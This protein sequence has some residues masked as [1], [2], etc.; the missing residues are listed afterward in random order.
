MGNRSRPLVALLLAVASLLLILA[1]RRAEAAGA[2]YLATEAAREE[3][4]EL[5]LERTDVAI[6]IAGSVASATVTQRFKNPLPMPIEVVYAFPLPQR[7]AV[8]AMEMKIGSRTVTASIARRDE[9]RAVY[10]SA[11][12]E[13]R[14]A[15]LLEQEHG[16]PPSRWLRGMFGNI[17]NVERPC[18]RRRALPAHGRP[19][20]TTPRPGWLTRLRTCCVEPAVTRVGTL[21]PIERELDRWTP[22]YGLSG[23]F[24]REHLSAKGAETGEKRRCVE[25][26]LLLQLCSFNRR[27][28]FPRLLEPKTMRVA[29][30]SSLFVTVLFAATGCSVSG[31]TRQSVTPTN[32]ADTSSDPSYQPPG[33]MNLA[34]GD[35][36]ATQ[37]KTELVSTMP[38]PN[39]RQIRRGLVH[40]AY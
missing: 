7:A 39:K 38:A 8:D 34:I 26:A 2:L 36:K 28:T 3:R 35:G 25:L 5:P 37:A 12:R 15:A 6:E 4:T 14:R 33:E 23:S 17:P 11:V 21:P 31:A 27:E 40:A 32:V 13:G 9:A 29:I 1:P 20:P 10:Q 18:D 24:Y 22:I 30:L 19:P 16:R